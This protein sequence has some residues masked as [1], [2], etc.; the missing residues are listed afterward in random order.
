MAASITKLSPDRATLRADVAEAQGREYVVDQAPRD[1]CGDDG[2]VCDWCL[3]GP[4]GERNVEDAP[5]AP[6]PLRQP[7]ALSVLRWWMF[8]ASR[9]ASS[10]A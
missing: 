7:L 4:G 3:F 8:N 6:P 9:V 2:V 1:S 10:R 5:E